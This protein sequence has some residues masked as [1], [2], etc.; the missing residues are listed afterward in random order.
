MKYIDAS[1][2]I[3]GRLSTVVAKELLNGESITI[4]NAS[5]VVVTGS[6]DSVLSKFRK[7]RDIGSVR[8]GPYYPR[9]PKA[10]LKRNIGDMLPKDKAKGREALKRCVVFNGVPASMK[11]INFERIEKAENAKVSRFVTLK[12]VAEIMGMKVE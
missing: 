7:R 11:D 9:V 2:L 4:V 10:I 3:Y 5:S 1:N 12:D 6:R 8:K